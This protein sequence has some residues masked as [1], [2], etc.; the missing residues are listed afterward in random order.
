MPRERKRCWTVD[1]WCGLD[2][3][4]APQYDS[5]QDHG[6]PKALIPRDE[7]SSEEDGPFPPRFLLQ[8]DYLRAQPVRRGLSQPAEPARESSVQIRLACAGT[9]QLRGAPLG[10]MVLVGLSA[11]RRIQLAIRSSAL[12]GEL[13]Q[14]RQPPPVPGAQTVST[15]QTRTVGNCVGKR[16]QS[17]RKAAPR[18]D[19]S[20]C[21]SL[22][23]PPVASACKYNDSG[24]PGKESSRH[25]AKT[26][27]F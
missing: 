10:A 2:S 24:A 15:T 26:S 14:S 20:F 13:G 11:S 17:G 4:F 23:R 3:S 25:R 6:S 7:E 22:M 9:S 18:P 12:V 27:E 5:E 19:V 21:V 8:G 1:A 16:T